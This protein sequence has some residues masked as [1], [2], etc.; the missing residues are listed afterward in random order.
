MFWFFLYL[1]LNSLG[2]GKYFYSIK[3]GEVN[4]L[5]FEETQIESVEISFKTLEHIMILSGMVRGGQWDYQRVTYDFKFEFAHDGS[6]YYFRIPGTAIVGEIEGRDCVV[7][8]GGPYLGRHY[9]PHG[10]EYNEEFPDSVVTKCKE[11]IKFIE[12]ALEELELKPVF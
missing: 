4:R 8:L 1:L 10:I 9:Y 12:S 2:V 6:V 3:I 5:K 11:R 7:K